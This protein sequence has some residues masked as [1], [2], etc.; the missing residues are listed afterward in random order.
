MSDFETVLKL[1]GIESPKEVTIIPAPGWK[2]EL[3][4]ILKEEL[5][6]TRDQRVLINTCL[7]EKDLKPHGQDIAKIVHAVLKDPGKLPEIVIG[8]EKELE[9][10][11]SV[12]ETIKDEYKAAV[13]IEEAE[14]SKEQKAKQAMPGKPA[15][16]VK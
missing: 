2:Y 1:A 9:A 12:K 15:I 11:E 13:K 14:K 16:V 4:R 5:K 7:S 8:K 10:Y 3:C 6:K